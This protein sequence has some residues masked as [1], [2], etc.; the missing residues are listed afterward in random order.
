MSVEMEHDWQAIFA[1]PKPKI[2]ERAKTRLLLLLCLLWVCFGLIGHTPWKPDELQSMSIIKHLLQG[3]SWVIPM[4]GGEA[5]LDVPPLYYLSAAAFAKVFS[6]LLPLHDAARLVTGIWMALTLT[7]VGMAGRELWGVGYGRQ[8]TLIFLG[9]IGLIFSA[10]TLNPDVAGL[11][12]FAMALY[13]FALAPRKPLRAGL[14]L[15]LGAAIG[16][17]AKGMFAIEAISACML[18]LPLLFY[19]WRQ[20]SYLLVMSI[21]IAVTLALIMPWLLAFKQQAPELFNHWLS[22]AR[23]GHANF[24]YFL[25]TLSWYTWPALP[26]AAWTLW[27]T[28]PDHASVQLPLLFLLITLTVLGISADNR[29]INALPLLLPFALLATPAVETLRRGAASALDWFGLMLFGTFGFLVW[30]G[31]FAMVSGMPEKLSQRLHKLSPTYT[32]EFNIVALILAVVLTLLWIGVVFKAN[33]RSNRAT[34]TDWAVGMTMVWG[35]VM[36]LWLP[37]LDAAKS[38][39]ATVASMRRELPTN[40]D[41]I[42]ARDLGDTQRAAFDYHGNIHVKRWDKEHA[43]ECSLYLIQDERDRPK[44]KPGP[45][46]RLIWQ[47]KRPSDRHESF[48][49]FQRAG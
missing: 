25:K 36:T 46:W 37:W 15:G 24:A 17:L 2:G 16:F 48:R 27:R 12:G 31:W 42:T 49:L 38:Y 1:T 30:L 18:L 5:D 8:A 44:I 20:K 45:E 13:A 39:Q 6:P 41:C 28:R 14:I 29:D 3:G 35:L 23:T 19:Y 7:F 40:Y 11:A 22:A 10:H 26:L 33:K 43:S 32:P 34:V 9:S 47:G 4:V 21:A